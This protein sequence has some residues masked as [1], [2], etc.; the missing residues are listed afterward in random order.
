VAGDLFGQSVSVSGD[1]AVIG[2][3]RQNSAQGAAYVFV[4]SGGTWSLQQKL[5]ASDGQALDQFGV[6]VSV[7]G[8]TAVIGAYGRNYYEGAAY[9]FVRSGVTWTQQQ[10]LTASDSAVNDD[11]GISVSVNANTALIG[12]F[13]NNSSQGAAYVFAYS[14]G[15]WSQQQELSASDGVAGDSFGDAVSVTGNTALIA[16]DGKNSKQG[17]AYVFAYDGTT[18]SQQQE[19]TASDGVASDS[20]GNSVSLG[21]NMAVIGAEGRGSNQGAAY[22]FGL[23]GGT[24]S[25]QQELSAS[26]GVAGDQFGYSVSVSGYTALVGAPAMNNLEGAAYV[27]TFTAGV[28][29]QQQELTAS[30]GA[31]SDVFGISV[32][33]SGDTALVGAT[34]NNSSQGAA[35][36]FVAQGTRVTLTLG[37]TG[38]G[39]I[40]ANPLPSGGT[41]LSGSYVC[42][43]AVSGTGW[44]FGSWSGAALDSS[45]CLV[46]SSDASV[47]ATFTT[48]AE[49][50]DVDPTATYSDAANLMFE[51]GVTTGCIEADTPQN[52]SYCPNDNVTRQEMAAF[53]VRAVTGTVNPA[54][55]NPTPYF[56][57]VPN[58]NPFF[59]HI[60]KLMD[61]GITTGCSQ[62]PALYCPTD[63]IPRWEMAI[64]MV[65]AR[66]LLYGASFTSSPTPYF[67]DVPTNVEGNGM[68]FPFIQRAYEEAV[69]NGCAADPLI[70]CPDEI[71]TRG[72]MASFVMRGLFNETMVLGPTAP[73]LAAVTP[74]AV[75]PTVG[76]QITVNITGANTSF[77]TGDTVS[78]LSGMLD[79]SNVVVNSTT[80][81]TATLTV[82]GTAVAGPQAIVVTSGGQ[83]L[84][85]PLAIKVG[86]Y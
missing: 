19:L 67:A 86:T 62:S 81:I 52:R 84:T 40:T 35:Y 70:F 71:V 85:L 77:Q 80:S 57:D 44:L 83:N 54:I 16:A 24:W 72:Q 3:Y 2:A 42:L 65:R 23:S 63:T 79:V 58:T 21:V 75:A 34:G 1:T 14:G 20:F 15:A 39:A 32:F 74:N 66:L 10:E 38:A 78:V 53:I 56:Q 25:Q 27:F 7:S 59:P 47:T 50:N 17:A 36:A 13:G 69:T 18:W 31:T 73:F 68:P 76:D 29:S 48:P 22:V 30:D 41:Y 45:N 28:W 60:Q 46:M 61:L 55:Y 64:F 51:A 12:A 4:R 9:V 11:F 6:S 26:D 82:N 49:F 37:V 8:D 5:T 33:A 43:T